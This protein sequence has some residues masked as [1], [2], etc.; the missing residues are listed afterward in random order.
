MAERKKVA[1]TYAYSE[2]WIAG[3]YYVIN[4]VRAI[5]TLP[6]ARKPHLVIVHSSEDGLG[7]IRELNYPYI[8]FVNTAKGPVSAI[9][10]F[11]ERVYRKLTGTSLSARR[12]LAGVECI[13]EGSP[14]YPFIPNHVYWVHDFQECR[15]PEFFTKEEA[16][17]RSALPKRL[18]TMPDAT[19]IVSSYDALNDYKKFF[20]G[21]QCKVRVWRF[22]SYLPDI[23]GI[24]MEKESAA[25]KVRSPYFLCSNQFWQHKN[26]KA[27]L[28]AINILKDRNLD[29][30]VVFTGKNFD[31]RNPHY[32]AGLESYIK[33][34]G[35]E[36]WVNFVGFIDRKVQLSLGKHAVAY[37]Q[38]SFF[39]GWSTTVEDAKFLNQL[40]ILS[41]IPVHREQLDHNVRF[42]NPSDPADLADAI[43]EALSGKL[44]RTERDY[45]THIR[46]Y[47]E[48]IMTTF[49]QAGK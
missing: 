41:D 26:H 14:D 24:D 35:L 40:V 23:S 38:P 37:I 34:N 13:F 21:Y 1:L 18:M 46:G 48:D 36:R 9:G 31:H 16:E 44:E 5:D 43:V 47:G 27:I 7:L 33:D 25:M 2:N 49:E 10:R 19:L 12:A 15:M 28:E 32:S 45:M 11:A 30:Q 6:D 39:E 4:M 3:S 20:P 29:Y 42:F 8:S 17:K 22:A